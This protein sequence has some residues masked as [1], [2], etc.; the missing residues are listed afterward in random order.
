M[1]NLYPVNHSSYRKNYSTER[2]LLRVKNDILLNM[3]KQR[4][5]LLALLDLSVA[6]DTVDHNVLLSR[7]HSKL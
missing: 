2:A 7:L 5:T 4:V 6:Y 1:N 3:K